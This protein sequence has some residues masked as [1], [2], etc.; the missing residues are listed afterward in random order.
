MKNQK[1]VTILALMLG[2]ILSIS[3]KSNAQ[4]EA[5]SDTG[6]LA[7]KVNHLKH[8][9]GKVIVNLFRKGDDIMGKPFLRKTSSISDGRASVAFEALPFADYVIFAF[10]DENDN[11]TMDHNWMNIP[12][13]P[14]GYSNNWNFSLFSGMPTYEKTKISFAKETG[15]IQIAI[16]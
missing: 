12:S 3:I 2:L 9:E 13:E 1:S 11:D 10:H 4:N 14:M 15:A 6:T 5:S 7:V 8:N 16:K